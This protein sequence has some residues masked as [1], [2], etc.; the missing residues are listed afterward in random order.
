MNRRGF[1]LIEVITSMVIIGIS[2]VALMQVYTLTTRTQYYRVSS[3][4]ISN[5]LQKKMEEVLAVKGNDFSTGVEDSIGSYYTGY[6]DV[7]LTVHE[8]S[9]WKSNPFLARIDVSAEWPSPQGSNFTETVSALV[10]D[11]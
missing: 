4:V 11:R 3:V 1:T 6:P 5:L 8:T 9:N 10:A 2:L 7:K